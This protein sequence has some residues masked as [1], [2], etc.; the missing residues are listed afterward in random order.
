MANFTTDNKINTRYIIITAIAV[1]LS[2][3]MH[4]IA[5]WATGELLGY[6]M[7]TTLNSTFP[8]SGKYNNDMHYQM[9]SAAG[10]LFTLLQAIVFFILM[11]Q[12]KRKLL[13]PFLFICLY[14]RLL[15]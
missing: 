11:W 13:Y 3:I 2:W 9:I 7:E 12:H 4:E 6:K 10:P 15:A 14:M 5:H 8:I 1:I